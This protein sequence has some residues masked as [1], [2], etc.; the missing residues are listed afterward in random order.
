MWRYIADN[1]NLE[2]PMKL[3]TGQILA[4]TPLP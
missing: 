4:I 1:N 3:K 2:D